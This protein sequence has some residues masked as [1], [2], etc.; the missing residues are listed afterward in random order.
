MKPA[1]LLILL[2]GTF[3]ACFGQSTSMEPSGFRLPT[4]SIYPAC[5]LAEKGRMLFNAIQNK[6]SYCNG[7][8]WIDAS[9]PVIATPAFGVSNP[10]EQ[11]LTTSPELLHLSTKDYDITDS[12]SYND[13]FNAPQNGIYKF[14]LNTDMKIAFSHPYDKLS[15]ALG[16]KMFIRI[17]KYSNGFAT[18]FDSVF[19]L[20]ENHDG[21]YLHLSKT[22]NLTV[23]D[24]IGVFVF[25]DTY[26]F[27][28]SVSLTNI[29]FSGQLV[30][31]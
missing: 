15:S 9:N 4:I 1:F 29:N 24:Q 25:L 27:P 6:V 8:S 17:V 5:T 13:I 14:D 31:K 10:L 18:V 26:S 20:K 16:T 7:T 2:I 21:K 11:T 3:A 28:G 22:L 12:W 23:G 30:A 19:S